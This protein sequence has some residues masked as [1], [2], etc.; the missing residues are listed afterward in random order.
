M[1]G[2]PGD[3]AGEFGRKYGKFAEGVW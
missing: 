3:R 2:R 1:G